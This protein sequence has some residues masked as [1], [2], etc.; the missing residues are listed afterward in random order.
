MEAQSMMFLLAVSVSLVVAARSDLPYEDDPKN[1]R[2][3]TSVTLLILLGSCI[4]NNETTTKQRTVV[5]RLKR[6]RIWSPLYIYFAR[7]IKQCTE[8]TCCVRCQL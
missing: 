5:T 4:S 8:A 1:L 3:S 6:K 7:R 2:G